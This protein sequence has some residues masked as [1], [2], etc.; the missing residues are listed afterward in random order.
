[1]V[2]RLHGVFVLPDTNAMGEGEHPEPVYNVRFEAGE[3]WGE[4][5]GPREK[6][7]LDLWESYLL[8]A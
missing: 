2:E 1:V 5:G 6:V 8:P 3:L 7:Y 4:S